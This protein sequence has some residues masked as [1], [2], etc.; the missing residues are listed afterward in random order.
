MSKVTVLER[1]PSPTDHSRKGF[2]CKTILF[3]CNCHT[4][5]EVESQLMKAIHCTPSRAKAIALEVH[6]K[7]NSVVYTGPKER[8]EAVAG[9]LEDIRLIVKISQ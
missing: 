8:C 2:A 6:T 9:V 1:S 7:G 4:F 3:N 5:D